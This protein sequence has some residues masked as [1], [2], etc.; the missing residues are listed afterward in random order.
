MINNEQLPI[1]CA[2]LAGVLFASGTPLAKLFLANISPLVLASLLYLGS[3]AGLIIC[4]ALSKIISVKKKGRGRDKKE[5]PLSKKDLPWLC[6]SIFFGSI[7]STIILMISLRHTPAITA[8][9]L[10]SFEAVSAALIASSIFHEP[11]GKRVWAALGLITIACLALTYS[12]G[13]EFWFSLGAFGIILTCVC[14]G[15]DTNIGRKISSKDPFL[16]VLAKG[17]VA[18]ILLFII[19]VLS[20]SNFPPIP[21]MI[22]AM[23]VGF[24]SF[25][26][27]MVIL[28]LYGL[29]GLGAARASSLFGMNPIFGVIVSLI[30]FHELPGVVFFIAL[31]FM[32]AGLYLLAT[33]KHSHPHTHPAETHE[34]RHFHPDIHHEHEHT[35][36]EALLNRNG[37][38]SHIH[39]HTEITHNHSHRPDI[40]HRHRHD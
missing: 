16:I 15:I 1:L 28:Y 4:F 36:G 10:L 29:R 26:G 40:H 38:H 14:W 37:Y 32:A 33:E 35:A 20:G 9:M 31:P 12:P 18:G 25:G 24:M 30:L 21:A 5:A 22:P 3:A 8:S 17:L 11:V 7:L 13:S 34:H 27:F 2:L 19:A 23:T 39:T 6:G